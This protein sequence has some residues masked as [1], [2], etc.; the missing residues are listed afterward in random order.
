[1][2]TQVTITLPDPVY[3]QA[4]KI[5][6][7]TQRNVQEVLTEVIT[8]NF[9]P[10][11]V[12]ENREAMLQEVEAFKALHPQLIKQYKGQYVAIYQGQVVDHDSDPVELLKRIKKQYPEQTVLRRKVED[13]PEPVLR[14]RSPRL[15][16]YP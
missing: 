11:P 7:S 14:F 5:A 8:Q 12:H 2:S 1:M 10:F 4:Q 9:Q 15:I 3:Q 6:Q 13:D 16:P